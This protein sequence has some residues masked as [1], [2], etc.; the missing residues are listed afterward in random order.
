MWVSLSVLMYTNG[1]P[2]LGQSMGNCGLA[3]A[4][5]SS[6]FEH[7]EA[8]GA[9]ATLVAGDPMASPFASQKARSCWRAS[10][11]SPVDGESSPL[12]INHE[13]LDRVARQAKVGDSPRDA[14]EFGESGRG[15]SRDS[16][17]IVAL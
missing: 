9:N 12:F 13:Q 17:Q 5:A 16:R 8:R 10:S 3:I 2:H 7:Q 1:V 6:A 15:A 14:L 11:P 4:P